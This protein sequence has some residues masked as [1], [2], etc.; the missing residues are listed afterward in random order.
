M[1]HICPCCKEQG[2][3]CPFSR[4]N[5]VRV[6]R[7]HSGIPRMLLYAQC[8]TLVPCYGRRDEVDAGIRVS[9]VPAT[10]PR[11]RARA[12]QVCNARTQ[13]HRAPI[14]IC[15]DRKSSSRTFGMSREKATLDLRGANQKSTKWL[16]AEKPTLVAKSCQISVEKKRV[17]FSARSLHLF[18]PFKQTGGRT[19][20]A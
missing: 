3:V 10:I 16:D 7:P 11:R 20:R 18:K 19:E 4:A 2:G 1:Q 6:G 8:D 13:L 5:H 17:D 12:I 9:P 15:S 14:P